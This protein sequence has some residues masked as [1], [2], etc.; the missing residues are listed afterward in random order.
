[1]APGNFFDDIKI[2]DERLT[3]RITVTEG[4]ILAY[5]GVAGDFSPLHMDEV[6]AQTTH[7]GGRVAHGLMG[8]TLTD[9]L[10]VQSAFFQDG[11]ALGW[12]WN[13]KG[14]IKIGDTL[15]ARFRIADARISRSRPEMGILVMAIHLINQR[16]EVVQEGEHRLMVPRKPELVG[17]QQ[18]A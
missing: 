3:P 17:Q 18:A 13:F 7:F 9:G 15:Q 1:M 4:H 8:L 16:G 12:T 2:G 14:P 10:K 6:Y 11:I 5:A